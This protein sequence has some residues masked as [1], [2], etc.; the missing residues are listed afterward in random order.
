[1]FL[2]SKYKKFFIWI[3]IFLTLV[4]NTPV[5]AS[6]WYENG[7]LHTATLEEWKKASPQNKLATCADLISVVIIN[8]YFK[9]QFTFPMKDTNQLKNYANQLLS[10]INIWANNNGNENDNAT[11]SE[12]AIISM[13]QLKWIDENYLKFL[14]NLTKN[15]SNTTTTK[16]LISS[17]PKNENN[18]TKPSKYHSKVKT[19]PKQ[20]LLS[21]KAGR[22]WVKE[23]VHLRLDFPLEDIVSRIGEYEKATKYNIEKYYFKRIDMTFFV[24]QSSHEFI[25]FAEG[26]SIYH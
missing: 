16:N 4:S 8:N 18:I 5:V 14:S 3:F 22:K 10:S 9:P 11:V 17:Y 12:T 2:F 15:K 13:L 24:I 21:K 6:E 1:M 25:G 23:N 20:K 7:N 26:K 19:I